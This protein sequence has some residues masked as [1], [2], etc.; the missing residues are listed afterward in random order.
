MKGRGPRPPPKNRRRAVSP[1]PLVLA[2]PPAVIKYDRS[3]VA[4]YW[5]ESPERMSLHSLVKPP[6]WVQLSA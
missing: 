6:H 3:R 2:S 4:W 1:G 5:E